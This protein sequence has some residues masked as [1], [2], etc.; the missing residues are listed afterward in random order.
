MQDIGP[1]LN[2]S[3][4]MAA[5]VTEC[6]HSVQIC[7]IQ[8]ELIVY[9][10]CLGLKSLEIHLFARCDL[11]FRLDV[12]YVGG[13]EC[14]YLAWYIISHVFGINFPRRFIATMSSALIIYLVS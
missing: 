14:D 12:R 7:R 2:Y 9:N 5:V 3:L 10:D 8:M 11:S 13:L 6:S 4:F 1:L